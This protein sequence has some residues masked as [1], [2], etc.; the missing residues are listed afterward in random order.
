MC[1][2]TVL[3]QVG[4]LPCSHY[5]VKKSCLILEGRCKFQAPSLRKFVVDTGKFFP[6]PKA[7]FLCFQRGKPFHSGQWTFF[8]V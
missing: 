4:N 3:E 7:L 8:H 6:F 5:T 1:F 2:Y